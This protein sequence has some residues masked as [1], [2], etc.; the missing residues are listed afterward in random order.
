MGE[1]AK[2][3][4]RRI[5]D[6]SRNRKFGNRNLA[7]LSIRDADRTRLLMAFRFSQGSSICGRGLLQRTSPDI[8]TGVHIRIYFSFSRFD[9][10]R[11]VIETRA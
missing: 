3:D 8:D 1:R 9:I 6:F 11:L 10:F 4:E 5:K 7:M 2:G